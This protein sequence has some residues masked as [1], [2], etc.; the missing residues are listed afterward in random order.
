MKLTLLRHGATEATQKRLYCGVSDIPLCPEGIDELRRM[1][2]DSEYPK[3]KVYYT[4][5]LLRTEQTLEILY[6]AVPH[7]KLPAIRETDFGQFELRGYAGDLEN[8]PAFRAWCAGNNG[9]NVCPGGESS[10][11][12]TARALAAFEEILDVGQDAVCITHGGVIAN[13]MCHWFPGA[14]SRY[15]YTPEP[16]KGYQ[17]LF[18][19]KTPLCWQAIPGNDLF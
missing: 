19:G 8:D 4:S 13:V 1:A 3:A 18:E 12:T 14:R 10:V 6:G 17:I 16:G 9:E 5:G 2:A 15:D 7:T 11:Q